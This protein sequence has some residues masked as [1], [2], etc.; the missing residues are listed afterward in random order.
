MKKY[1]KIIFFTCLFEMGTRRNIIDK[2]KFKLNIIDHT[3]TC[4]NYFFFCC[5]LGREP[6]PH[7]G[8]PLFSA[9]RFR[10]V[11]RKISECLIFSRYKRTRHLFFPSICLGLFVNDFV[12]PNLT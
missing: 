8:A 5:F 10:S 6:R 12:K 2:N 11:C 7:L 9:N 3:F 4:L 1:Y